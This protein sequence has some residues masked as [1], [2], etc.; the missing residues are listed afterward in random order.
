MESEKIDLIYEKEQEFLALR[1][2]RTKENDKKV[3]LD[4]KE[5]C[6]QIEDEN[7]DPTQILNQK[8]TLIIENLGK[9]QSEV[10]NNLEAQAEKFD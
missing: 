8:L 1:D 7:I 6:K 4:I 5:Q 2:Q 10:M 9:S 3:I